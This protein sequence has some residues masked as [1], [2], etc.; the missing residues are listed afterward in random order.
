[1][2]VSIDEKYSTGLY[3]LEMITDN[4]ELLKQKFTVIP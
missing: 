4:G 1:M 2:S 3:I